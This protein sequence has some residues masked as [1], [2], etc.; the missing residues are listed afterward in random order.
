MRRLFSFQDRIRLLSKLGTIAGAMIA[1]ALM[2][3]SGYAGTVTFGS[4]ANTFNMEFVTIGNPG[5]APDSVK[6]SG[7]VGY[8]FQLGK[9]EV[10]RDMIDRYNASYG[11][12]ASLAITLADMSSTDDNGGD[13]PATGV[14]WNEA[15]R[16]V[17][18]LN[19][20]TGGHAAYKFTSSG[21]NDNISLWESSDEADYNEFNPFR[22]KR[23]TYVLPSY[24]EWYKAA[25]YDPAK[26]ANGGYWTYPTGSD[27]VPT[28]ITSNSTT[29]GTAVYENIAGGTV[30]VGQAGGESAYQIMGMAGNALEWT[31]SN[32]DSVNGNHSSV[33][34]DFIRVLLG[35]G[36]K[37]QS[38]FMS[39]TYM[40]NNLPQDAFPTFQNNDFGFRVA[41]LSP[42]GGGGEVPEPTSMAIFGLGA[43]GFV[44]RAHRKRNAQRV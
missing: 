5:N 24:Q 39:S 42:G 6:S 25:Y 22:S 8:T 2:N 37:N 28:K 35:G 7:S 27:S 10:S 40:I 3:A 12:G 41:V 13:R 26:G 36:F 43:L 32:L 18:W 21:V 44:Y 15:A 31:E 34:P 17:N 30:D 20:S 38:Q 1:S 23:A 29:S 11:N 33:N 14:S 9:T 19:T 16:F 4:G